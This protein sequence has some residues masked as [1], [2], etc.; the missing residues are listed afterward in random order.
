MDIEK[1]AHEI[2][3]VLLQGQYANRPAANTDF[4]KSAAKEYV[5]CKRAIIGRLKELSAQ[6][7]I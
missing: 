4:A 3:M 2:T 1:I 7:G 5:D 6:D